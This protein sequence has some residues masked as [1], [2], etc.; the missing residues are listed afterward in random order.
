MSVIDRRSLLRGLTAI[1]ILAMAG[2]LGT[3]ML[4]YLRPTL[5]PLEF[6]QAEQPINEPFRAA[7]LSEFPQD[8]SFKEFVFRQETVEYTAR[9]KQATDI[10]GFIVRIPNGDIP[11]EVGDAANARRGYAVAQFGGQTYSM[12]VVSRICP[13]LG[14]IFQYHPPAT[15]CSDFN[16]CGG[17]NNLFACPCHLS[18]YD[19]TLTQDVGG[20]PLPGRVVSGPA[21]R[22]PF[23]FDFTIDGGTIIIQ[24]YA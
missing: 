17:K 8:Y 16:F 11:A 4:S 19:P 14:C 10:P 6:P 18:V 2:G 13:H 20:V 3:A 9:G 12:V 5:R 1:P 15:V 21:P 22:P 7:S 24:G 23:P